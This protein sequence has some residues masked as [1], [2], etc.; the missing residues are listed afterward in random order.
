M[1]ENNHELVGD[2]DTVATLMAT[3]N[4]LPSEVP[5]DGPYTDSNGEAAHEEAEVFV[6]EDAASHAVN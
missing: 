1:N 4:G 2:A 3:N 5:F 6:S